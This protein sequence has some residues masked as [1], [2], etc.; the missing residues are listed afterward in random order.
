MSEHSE[1]LLFMQT[2]VFFDNI[3]LKLCAVYAILKF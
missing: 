1:R 3:Y 2:F